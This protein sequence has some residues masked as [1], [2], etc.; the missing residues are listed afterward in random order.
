M[1]EK[2]CLVI[3]GGRGMGAATAREMHKRG[4]KLSLM[5]PSES[6]EQ[7]AKDA[8]LEDKIL[9]PGRVS[10]DEVRP[11]YS[12][13]DIFAYPRESAR[14]TELVTPLKPLEAMSM[15][16]SVIGSNV[17]GLQELISDGETGLI[18]RHD[19]VNDLAAKIEM[20]ADD[21]E[22]R[23]K[24]GENGRKFVEE[25][26]EWRGIIEKH[27]DVYKAARMNWRKRRYTWKG[28]ADLASLLGKGM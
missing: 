9:H 4:Y 26:R 12:V 2:T 15:K 22:L 6:C 8:G 19:D 23:A 3:G 24:F 13:V 27:F 10:H 21:S 18:H 5:S 17:G 1:R 7:L 25:K 16:K 11:L 20:L 28:I 14:I